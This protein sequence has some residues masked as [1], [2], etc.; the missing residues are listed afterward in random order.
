MEKKK[1]KRKKKE[2]SSE[3]PRGKIRNL[4]GKELLRG[5]W[6]VKSEE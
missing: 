2:S 5:G 1:K 4:E 3:R 6:G